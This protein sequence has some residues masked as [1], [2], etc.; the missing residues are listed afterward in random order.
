MTLTV[1]FK[2]FNTNHLNVPNLYFK[3]TVFH[4]FIQ[5]NKNMSVMIR[6][7]L[8]GAMTPAI[9]RP[10]VMAYIFLKL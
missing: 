4:M 2:V 5:S 8:V 6:G 10:Q 7:M 9:R 3:F 1:H